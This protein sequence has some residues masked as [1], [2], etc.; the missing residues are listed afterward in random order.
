[1]K[2][3]ESYGE[4]IRVSGP[5]VD[6]RFKHDAI[7]PL[8]TALKVSN[9]QISAKDFN[10]V[11]EV[12]QH[13]GDGIVRCIAMDNTNGLQR[14]IDVKNT[15][16]PIMMPVGHETL[17]RILNSSG[18]SIDLQGPVEAQ[19]YMPIHRN[20]PALTDLKVQK[21][22][23]VTGIKVID[24]L[25]PCQKGGKI[26]LF[27]GTGVGKT[28]MVTELIHNVAMHHGGYSVFAGVGERT[29]EARALYTE[30]QECG[31]LDKTCLVFSHMNEP[32]GARARVALA[33]LTVAE[34]FRD[35]MHQDILFFIDNVYRFSQAGAE[36]SALLGRLPS[37]VGYQPTLT[38]EMGALQERITSTYQG[39]IT[40]IQA[41]YVPGDDFTDPAAAAAFAHL[42]A[43]IS[44]SRTIAEQGIYPA[45]DPLKSS[46]GFLTAENVGERHYKIAEDTLE[47][48]QKYQE[49]KEIIAVMGMDE[50]TEQ[51][52]TL[53]HRARKIQ[54][55]LSQP[56]Y[57]AEAFSDYKGCF[58]SLEET[59]DSFEKILA[60]TCDDIAEHHFYMK[61]SL[62]SVLHSAGK[63]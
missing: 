39:S 61:A 48:L 21:D 8:L 20:P 17:G 5:V 11:L 46:S 24:L 16:T 4:V 32:P 29:R 49:L 36:V 6:V 55:F 15:Q 22:L 62:E 52:K 35:Q 58:V 25:S 63:N 1:M 10:M 37:A 57:T 14:H 2:T 40:S 50:L 19:Q 38:E 31:V 9:P 34:Y 28:V 53:V 54:K 60:G 43:T 30:M 42:D 27:G 13:L 18:S 7:P 59:L 51:D 45:V 23:L 3:L 26:G 47:L 12:M 44:L 33:A 41:V 56:F